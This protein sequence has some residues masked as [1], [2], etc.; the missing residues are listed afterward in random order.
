MKIVEKRRTIVPYQRTRLLSH[1]KKILFTLKTLRKLINA[2][3]Y[4]I[5]HT[6]H[7]DFKFKTIHEEAKCL[8]RKFHNFIH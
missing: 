4:I 6:L 3:A 7:S 5:N 2:S 1:E 8:Y